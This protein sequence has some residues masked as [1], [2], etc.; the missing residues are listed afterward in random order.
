MKRLR[1]SAAWRA[2]HQ[3]ERGEVTTQQLLYLAIGAI[4]AAALYKYGKRLLAIVE[5]FIGSAEDQD[6]KV[7]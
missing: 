5:G 7:N 2:F 3:D 4:V 6:N 1:S